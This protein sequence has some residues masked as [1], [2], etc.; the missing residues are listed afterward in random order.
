MEDLTTTTD[1]PR[2]VLVTG[3]NGAIGAPVT[4]A[5]IARGHRVRGFDLTPPPDDLGLTDCIR[6]DLTDR[7]ALDRA[8]ADIEVCIHLAAN[9]HGHATW[10]DLMGPNIQGLHHTWEAACDAG[11]KRMIPASTVQTVLGGGW[12]DYPIVPVDAPLR[13]RNFYAAT[14]CLAEALAWVY[15]HNRGIEVILVRPGFFPR[16]AKEVARVAGSDYGPRM[17]W[18][19][20]DA[21]R[22]YTLAVEATDITF[23]TLYGASRHERPFFDLEP[24]RE[25]IG[26]EPQDRFPDGA[27]EDES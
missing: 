9:P 26:Y 13:P 22:F 7:P 20:R 17:Y 10:D 23:V 1:T 21:A 6:A 11:V 12:K 18:S 15:H 8:M 3:C 2:S 16:D 25:A 14:K 4:R 19:P 5:L 24:A 27:P